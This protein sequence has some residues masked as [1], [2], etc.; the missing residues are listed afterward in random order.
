MSVSFNPGPGPEYDEVRDE[1]GRLVSRTI[2][3]REPAR[4]YVTFS[5]VAMEDEG[6]FLVRVDLPGRRK[7]VKVVGAVQAEAGGNWSALSRADRPEGLFP[8]RQAAAEA[9]VKLAGFEL[10]EG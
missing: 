9:L 8:H 1:A 4:P 6:R 7:A 3:N 2:R 5:L 10:L